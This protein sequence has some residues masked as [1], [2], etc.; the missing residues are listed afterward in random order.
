MRALIGELKSPDAVERRPDGGNDWVPRLGPDFGPPSTASFRNVQHLDLPT[1]LDNIASRS[2]VI[3]LP[4]AERA[5]TLS[6]VAELV[7]T[8]PNTAGRATYH[9][10]YLTR[11]WR[12]YR[13]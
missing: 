1:L 3:E 11:C 7:R 9:L 6:A 13:R 4:D 10:P 12:A 8:H 5:R 2:Y